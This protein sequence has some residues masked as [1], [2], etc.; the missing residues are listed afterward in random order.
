MALP[1]PY[2]RTLELSRYFTGLT[3]TQVAELLEAQYNEQ[4]DNFEVTLQPYAEND[5]ILW[6]A[7]VYY[8]KSKLT[9]SD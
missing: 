2:S 6:N 9:G 4:C 7:T 3:A 1:A 5:D 8:S